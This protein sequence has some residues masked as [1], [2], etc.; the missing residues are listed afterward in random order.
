M[1]KTLQLALLSSALLTTAPLTADTIV[2]QMN[3]AIEA[4]K[5]KDYKGAMEELKFITAEIQKLDANENQKLL[6]EPLDGW[7]VEQ[8]D[9]GSQAMVS[10]MGGGS[11]VEATY[12]KEEQ[13]VRI[14]ILANSPM[15]AMMSMSIANPALMS[16]DPN[17]SPFRYKRNKGMKQK[18]GDSVEI[19]LLIAGQIMLQLSGSNL[20]DEK[21]LEAYLDKI[22]LA[23][24][25][26]TL[27]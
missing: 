22:D 16:A 24:L 26:G 5:A 10:M 13:S 11:T 2:D 6:P 20:K 8:S 23:K 25:K 27:L 7:S 15:I 21:T 19:T 9:N 18:E 4:Y 14:Q 1:K 12:T 3:E 17:T